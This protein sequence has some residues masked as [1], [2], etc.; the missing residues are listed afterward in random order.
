MKKL[1]QRL[2][3]AFMM[4][5]CLGQPLTALADQV[6]NESEAIVEVSDTS[7]E[8]DGDLTEEVLPTPP[9]ID[10]PL[11]ELPPEIPEEITPP[12]EETK[13]EVTPQPPETVPEVDPD[14]TPTP[15]VVK[16]IEQTPGVRVAPEVVDQPQVI[17][18][19]P[20]TEEVA[21]TNE[22]AVSYGSMSFT[23]DQSTEAFILRL[24]K[25]ARKI[26]QEKN[27][28]ASVMIA[29]A[30]LESASGNSQLASEPNYNLFG[31]KGSFEGQSVTFGT[32]E[33]D[34][35]GNLYMID[36]GFKKYP[37][38]KESLEDYGDLIT[39][40]IDGSP[41]FYKGTWKSDAKSYQEATQFLTGRYA[42]DITYNQKLN[43]LI[44]TYQLTRY[45]REETTTQAVT[46][47]L[48][49]G[50]TVSSHYGQRGEETHRGVDF[51]APSG[52]PIVSIKSGVVVTSE[53]NSSWGE[54]VVVAHEDG[55]A[56]LYAH[57]SQRLV[58][59]GD[60]VEAGDILG[61]VGST[62]DSTGPHLHWEI[63]L[64]GSLSNESLIDPLSILDH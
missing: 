10:L 52:S 44:E 40:G 41:E 26:G 21:V 35:S 19:A 5:S 64:D 45:D 39:K 16:P 7:T 23:K 60:Q 30:I 15:E 34:G 8:E 57:Q 6:V 25:E 50:G 48:P 18:S 1:S 33:D 38:Y 62:G 31:I 55:M 53:F 58:K 36:A 63:S 14:I 22:I 17:N 54:Y 28:Y 59:V 3:I 42:T 24:G 9:E 12:I 29:Q 47:P 11:E 13:P 46:H 4:F 20:T 2:M 56:S 49:E 43:G 27:I 61:L 51:A 37:S 32:Q